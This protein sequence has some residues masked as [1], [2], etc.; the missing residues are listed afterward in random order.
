[1]FKR[2][3]EGSPRE[4]RTESESGQNALKK[5]DAID[6]NVSGESKDGTWEKVFPWKLR[7]WPQFK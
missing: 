1:V 3:L 2:I 4:R 6:P 5:R 7:H